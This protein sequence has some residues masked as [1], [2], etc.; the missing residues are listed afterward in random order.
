M[1]K[2]IEIQRN[3]EKYI[4]I[5]RIE[6]RMLQVSVVLCVTKNPFDKININYEL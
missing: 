2:Y 1:L 5:Q 6:K 3:T 4:E